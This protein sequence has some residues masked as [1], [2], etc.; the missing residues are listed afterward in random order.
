MTNA[1]AYQEA[2]SRSAVQIDAVF[3]FITAVSLF[4]FFLVEGLLIYFAVR[5]RRKKASEDAATSD[6]TSN[7]VLEIVWV[8]IPSLVV[9]AFFVYGYLVY[10]DVNTP[11]PGS[12]DI[13]VVAEQFNFEFKYADGR[14]EASE[15]RVPVGKPVK[16]IMT[17]RDVIHGFFL[18]D[19]RLKQDILPGQYT[20]LYLHPDREGTYD[21]FCTQYCGVGHSTMRAKLV[22]MPPGEYAKWAAGGKFAQAALPLSER[23]KAL[24]EKSGCL[25]CHT[26][27]GTAKIGPTFK[28]LYGRKVHLE[29]GREVTADEEYIRESLYDPGAKI[30]RGFPNVMPTFKGRLSDDDVAAVIAYLK[31]LS[32][33]KGGGG[34]GEKEKKERGGRE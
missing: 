10:R 5:Y 6:V 3:I 15:L 31:T 16:L 11:S 23:G 4:F 2:A 18:P 7:L 1:Y 27:D 20:Y 14:T 30:V 21:I 17:S 24:L 26:T 34:K 25:G 13:N 8:L 28:G 12:S 29:G 32:E 19:F 22:V 9:L 33:G